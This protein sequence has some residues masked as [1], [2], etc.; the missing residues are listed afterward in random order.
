MFFSLVLQ[1]VI[2][3]L[4]GV[5][6]WLWQNGPFGLA[7]LYGGLVAVVN[8]GMLVVRWWRGLKVYHCD[9]QRH[10]KTFNRSV[11]ERFFVVGS[12]LALG[13]GLLKLVPL[14]MLAGFVVG[15]TAWMLAMMLTRRLP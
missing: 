2:T 15:Q 10:L 5:I 6:G 11:L 14:A 8:S 7:I 4:A 9:G 1:L 3:V 13:F 12:L